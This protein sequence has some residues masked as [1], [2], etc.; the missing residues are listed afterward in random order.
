M[1]YKVIWTPR[2]LSTLRELVSY[3]AE[4]NPA[5]A[6]RLGER[7]F[8]KVGLIRKHPLIAARFQSLDRDDIR[9]FPVPP[10]RLIYRVHEDTRTI[11][12]LTVWHGA[13]DEPELGG[14]ES[15]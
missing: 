9:D 13:R 11:H 4:R 8:E 15:E 5:A 10:V 1:D 3:V 7:I 6:R 2:S 14:S 12:I